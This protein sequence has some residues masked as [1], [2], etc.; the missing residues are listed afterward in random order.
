MT[1]TI[2]ASFGPAKM[3]F[4]S[5]VPA[6]G[7]CIACKA[8]LAIYEIIWEAAYLPRIDSVR[9]KTALTS[10]LV[11]LSPLAVPVTGK[12]TR[13]SSIARR[14]E[15]LYPTTELRSDVKV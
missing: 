7:S 13:W 2:L 5:S 3:L 14:Y 1:T 11:L 8:S 4:K 15:W 6:R 9:V 12:S 10:S